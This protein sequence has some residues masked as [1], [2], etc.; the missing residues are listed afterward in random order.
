MVGMDERASCTTFVNV[1]EF[2]S[3]IISVVRGHIGI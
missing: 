3:I 2:K 1:A